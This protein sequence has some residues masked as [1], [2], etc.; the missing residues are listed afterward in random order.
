M[1]ET[2]TLLS[3]FLVGLLGSSHCLGMC[4]GLSMALGLH[5]RGVSRLLGYQFGRLSSYTLLGAL[6]GGSSSLLLQQQP[7]LLPWLRLFSALLVIMMGLH[8]L[9]L[10]SL[11]PRI[12][13]IGGRL[14]RLISPAANKALTAQF[15]AS[16]ILIGALWGW[17]P[18]GLVY[19]MASWSLSSASSSQGALVMLFFGLG[20]LPA[21]LSAAFFSQQLRRWLNHVAIKW[22]LGLG[23]LLLGSVNALH[24]YHLL[25]KL[26]PS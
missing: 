2:T 12:E 20:T 23:L 17:L 14:W 10:W 21:M 1:F 9:R 13:A 16:S 8:V 11:I 15:P 25:I 22:L 7:Q 6:L 4:G 3:A 5:S 26:Q 19:S 18:C 24:A